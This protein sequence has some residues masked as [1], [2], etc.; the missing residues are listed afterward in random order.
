VDLLHRQ[1]QGLD[2]PE[3]YVPATDFWI[4]APGDEYL[5]RVNIRHRLTPYL[6][7]FGGHIGYNVRSK[8][9]GKGIATRALELGLL[10]ARR[11]G[12]T[13]VLLTCDDDNL[14]SRR[15]I[16]KNGGVL[17]DVVV[18]YTREDGTKSVIAHK[19]RYWV[20]A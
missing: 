11:L 7:Q 2:L 14:A 8:Y 1:S 20:E 13:R 19:R 5:G 4:V 3:G 16:E 15:V 10:E 18:E 9:R 12:L 6:A 17:E